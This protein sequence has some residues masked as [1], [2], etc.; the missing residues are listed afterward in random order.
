MHQR[1]GVARVE[2]TARL[3]GVWHALHAAISFGGDDGFERR[4]VCC[5]LRLRPAPRSLAQARAATCADRS[6]P[7]T[8]T[9]AEHAPGPTSSDELRQ[10]V[11]RQSH[12]V[13]ALKEKF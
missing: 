13:A 5:L 6:G 8:T 4:G 11:L 10:I 12:E 7:M 3:S 1:P 2:K 9:A